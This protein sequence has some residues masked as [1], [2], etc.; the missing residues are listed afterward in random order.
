[1]KLHENTSW[2]SENTPKI[3]APGSLILPNFSNEF[4]FV[5]FQ[6]RWKNFIIHYSTCMKACR[7]CRCWCYYIWYVENIVA[8]CRFL[9]PSCYFFDY[10]DSD[11]VGVHILFTLFSSDFS[12]EMSYWEGF[13]WN[14]LCEAGMLEVRG[15]GGEQVNRSTG[16]FVTKIG[17]QKYW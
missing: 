2:I 15:R 17:M 5:Y 10:E 14:C 16:T 4:T 13:L 3:S 6:E 9:P 11:Y 8:W 7:L 1:M 12:N